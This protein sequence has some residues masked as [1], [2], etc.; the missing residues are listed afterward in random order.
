MHSVLKVSCPVTRKMRLTAIN[1]GCAPGTVVWNLRVLRLKSV[2]G[3]SDGWA[4]HCRCRSCYG[5][6]C[7][8]TAHQKIVFGSQVIS[9]QD[10]VARN[11]R[12]R[13]Q[14]R[15]ANPSVGRQT[16]PRRRRALPFPR[17]Q[18]CCS[19]LGKM[20]VCPSKVLFQSAYYT[21]HRRKSPVARRMS[22]LA[23]VVNSLL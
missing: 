22:G 5:M 8:R 2:S 18:C 23:L 20:T 14:T 13:I 15:Q 12:R 16:K 3:G 6:V 21:K 10:V 17:V 1:F 4:A 11:L 9:Y 19:N 7:L